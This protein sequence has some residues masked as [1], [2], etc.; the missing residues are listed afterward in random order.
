M[1]FVCLNVCLF[2]CLLHA[3]FV[4][5][6]SCSVTALQCITRRDGGIINSCVCTSAVSSQAS[7]FHYAAPAFPTLPLAATA[8]VAEVRG[9]RDNNVESA[10]LCGDKSMKKEG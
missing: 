8:G 3:R 4:P 7:A 9:P 10:I 5:R 1:W 2:C 6:E